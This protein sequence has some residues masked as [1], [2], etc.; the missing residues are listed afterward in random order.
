MPA[1]IP[2]VGSRGGALRHARRRGRRQ[3][4][5]GRFIDVA[6]EAVARARAGDGPTLI[7][8]K[9]YRTRA[10]AEG[11]GD[12]TYR[13]REDVDAWK[14]RCPI[15]ALRETVLSRSA[16]GRNRTGR[17]FDAID[18]EV[19]RAGSRSAA[20]SPKPVPC[21]DPATATTHVYAH[22]PHS[23]HARGIAAGRRRDDHVLAR[24]RSKRSTGE[25]ARNP[26]D[27]R[28]GR[29]DRQ[30]RRQLPDDHGPVRPVRPR[31][32]VRHADLRA[33]LRR[34]GL[35]RGDDRHAAGDRLHVR[36]LRPRRRSARSSTRSPRCSTCRA[37]G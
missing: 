10:H 36:R 37:A 14:Q 17:Q 23:R 12:F 7:E 22:E 30:T 19:R 11:M 24:R 33:R 21:P 34:P 26:T 18:A 16:I 4:R 27:L 25:M 2:D 9:T 6:G 28:D 3:R 13:T 5:A 32:A 20:S 8:C 29:R 35:R 1:A 15:A 31:A